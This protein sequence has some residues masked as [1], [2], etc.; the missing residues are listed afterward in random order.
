MHWAAVTQ[1]NGY[2]DGEC[3]EYDYDLDHMNI[4]WASSIWWAKRYHDS[5][6]DNHYD[7]HDD[8]YHNDHDSDYASH[9][10]DNHDDHY[11]D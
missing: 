11:S 1:L 4:V 7:N 3:F 2:D 9:Y 8:H 10:Y 5:D 6:Y